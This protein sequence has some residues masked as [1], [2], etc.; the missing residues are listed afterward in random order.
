MRFTSA[1]SVTSRDRERIGPAAGGDGAQLLL[2][3]G[4]EQDLRAAGGQELSCCGADATAGAGDDDDLAV[5][6]HVFSRSLALLSR[7]LRN[8]PKTTQAGL[9]RH[10]AL[11]FERRPVARIGARVA[12]RQGPIEAAR[13]DGMSTGAAQTA[14]GS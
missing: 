4:H 13:I 5:D 8:K 2:V 14:L 10:D 9:C 3:A 7:G 1:R 11:R 12:D 6:G